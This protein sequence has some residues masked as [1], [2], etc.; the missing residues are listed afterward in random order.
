MEE[1]E[2]EKKPKEHRKKR[3]GSKKRSQREPSKEGEVSYWSVFYG[4]LLCT[5][6]IEHNRV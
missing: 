3:K 4:L 5:I 1:D 6:G 2:G